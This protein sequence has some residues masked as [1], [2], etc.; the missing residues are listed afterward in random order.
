VIEKKRVEFCR[1]AKKCRKMQKSAQVIE[2]KGREFAVDGEAEPQAR[3]GDELFEISR[4]MITRIYSDVKTD[5][6]S[7]S[8][9]CE[10]SRVPFERLRSSI[11]AGCWAANPGWPEP[12][13]A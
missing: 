5:F 7:G 3:S 13:W 11:T 4:H 6:R 10:D 9:D 1:E 2:K 12:V 8:A